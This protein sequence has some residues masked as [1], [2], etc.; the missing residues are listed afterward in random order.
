M[1]FGNRKKKTYKII[2]KQ[3]KQNFNTL[4]QTSKRAGSLL[5]NINLGLTS[6]TRNISTTK[7]LLTSDNENSSRSV[8]PSSDDNNVTEHEMYSADVNNNLF[9]KPISEIPTKYM[10]EYQDTLE[11][12]LLSINAEDERAEE[13]RKRVQDR[14]D[15]ILIEKNTRPPLTSDDFSEISSSDEDE[16]EMSETDNISKLTNLVLTEKEK[17][18]IKAQEE[19]EISALD[20]PEVVETPEPLDA[21]KVTEALKKVLQDQETSEKISEPSETN[22]VKEFNISETENKPEAASTKKRKFEEEQGESSAQPA[23]RF[24]QDSSDILPDTEFPD[25]F[26]MGGE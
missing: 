5:T 11:R 13:G 20:T 22:E 23:T 16:S 14:L 26:D 9:V 7:A 4:L 3:K 18:E 24:K 8:T 15:D 1:F 12:L 21:D 17:T 2:I 19:K 25:I 10:P 6:T